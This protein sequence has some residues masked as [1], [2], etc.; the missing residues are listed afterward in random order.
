MLINQNN[1]AE[2]NNSST[3]FDRMQIVVLLLGVLFG[4]ILSGGSYLIY[5]YTQNHKTELLVDDSIGNSGSDIH[6]NTSVSK[7]VID[8][9]NVEVVIP[10]YDDLL[11]LEFLSPLR[12]RLSTATF[13]ISFD[14]PIL[15]KWKLLENNMRYMHADVYAG[16]EFAINK[17]DSDYYNLTSYKNIILE[18]ASKAKIAT[19]TDLAVLVKV[20]ED[21]FS[22]YAPTYK[23]EVR[24]YKAVYLE[25]DSS[26]LPNK[27]YQV[28]L[29]ET[30]DDFIQMSEFWKVPGDTT[31]PSEKERT[32][33]QEIL[34]MASNSL[35]ITEQ[36]KDDSIQY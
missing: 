19:E 34:K 26:Y 35:V 27:P 21:D 32:Q 12:G 29:L 6:V 16:V 3:L 30:E 14:I 36:P 33:A 10:K 15:E 20:P 28:V 9:K 4:V 18:S 17:K 13:S 5:S 23:E 25:I 22:Y 24:K 2:N 11:M 7:D 31:V 8:D 1:P